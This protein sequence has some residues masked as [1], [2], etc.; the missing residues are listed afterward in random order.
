MPVGHAPFGR[1]MDCIALVS[2]T[3]AHAA[4]G[5]LFYGQAS[6]L[7]GLHCACEFYTHTH[8]AAGFADELARSWPSNHAKWEASFQDS[9]PNYLATL[10][11]L[12]ANLAIL[13]AG[14]RRRRKLRRPAKRLGPLASGRPSHLATWPAARQGTWPPGQRPAK[15]LGPLA[16]GRPRHLAPCPAAGQ[17][18]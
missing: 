17:A 14:L 10:A 11:N 8:A 1:Q 4:T 15:R 12:M 18:T 6:C 16:S 2:F 5:R 7:N 13:M 9:P 3:H